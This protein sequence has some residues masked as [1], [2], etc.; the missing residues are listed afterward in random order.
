MDKLV[1]SGTAAL[2][3]STSTLRRWEARGRLR[4]SRTDGGQRRYDH[5]APRQQ[6]QPCAAVQ[7]REAQCS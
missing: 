4:P 6:F 1:P 2:G 5:A 3:A 7:P